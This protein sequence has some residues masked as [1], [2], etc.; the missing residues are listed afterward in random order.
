M[1][2]S[3]WGQWSF[4][5]HSCSWMRLHACYQDRQDK[6]K[7]NHFW[8]FSNMWDPKYLPATQVKRG[9]IRRVTWTTPSVARLT[10][11]VQLQDGRRGGNHKLPL[12]ISLLE[13]SPEGFILQSPNKKSWHN[14]MHQLFISVKIPSLNLSKMP[15]TVKKK[16]TISMWRVRPLSL[17]ACPTCLPLKARTSTTPQDFWRWGYQMEDFSGQGFPREWRFPC[18]QLWV[19]TVGIEK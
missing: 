14:E 10:S 8:F 15:T 12:F 13:Q 1:F 5:W 17:W 9:K 18:H 2:A 3:S 6:T 11:E 7:Q 16:P 4:T 19:F